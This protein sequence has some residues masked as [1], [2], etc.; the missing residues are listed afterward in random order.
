MGYMT[1]QATLTSKKQTVTV[2]FWVDC[3]IYSGTIIVKSPLFRSFLFSLVRV[4]PFYPFS[5]WEIWNSDSYDRRSKDQS[6]PLIRPIFL[7]DF[8]FWNSVLDRRGSGRERSLWQWRMYGN[9]T[10][11]RLRMKSLILPVLWD[12]VFASSKI[13]LWKGAKRFRCINC[14]TC[15]RCLINCP[16]LSKQAPPSLI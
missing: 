15:Q 16:Q 1:E 13:R 12:A 3:L 6:E 14:K 9:A 5:R 8:G 7:E 2:P 10:S 4:F 11:V